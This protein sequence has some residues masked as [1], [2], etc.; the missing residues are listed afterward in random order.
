MSWTSNWKS[1]VRALDGGGVGDRSRTW[2]RGVAEGS[3]GLIN[4]AVPTG[5][6]EE[7]VTFDICEIFD[8]ESSLCRC[9]DARWEPWREPCREP[10]REL[11]FDPMDCLLPSEVSASPR[12]LIR[13]S[14]FPPLGVNLRLLLTRLII[15]WRILCWS[16]QRLLHQLAWL[17]RVRYQLK[18]EWLG[19]IRHILQPPSSV[20]TQC[21]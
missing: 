18:R 13:T 19:N 21:R 2:T 16:P 10:C 12:H 6:G 1:S 5:F 15:T 9:L 4:K 7:P 14:T 17:S 11:C 3:I 20:W 8:P